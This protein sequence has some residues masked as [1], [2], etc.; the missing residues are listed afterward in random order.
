MSS[1]V[2]PI[3][4]L[5]RKLTL[6]RAILGMT[7]AHIG[8][9]VV[10]HRHHAVESYTVER[11]IALAPGETVALGRYAFRFDSIRE[12]EG[13]NYEG[14]RARGHGAARRASR[15]VILH[16]EK[17]IYWVQNSVHDR[18]GHR[19]PLEHGSVRGAR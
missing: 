4:R 9:G 18:S 2:D 8:L 10:R 13:P 12:I 11:D 14:V 15:I 3:D 1:L 6:S 17:R 16:P 19:E 7:V 5:R